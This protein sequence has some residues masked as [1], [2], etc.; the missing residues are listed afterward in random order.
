MPSS[1]ERKEGKWWWCGYSVSKSKRSVECA[2]SA[3]ATTNTVGK[4]TTI[5]EAQKEKN[6][7][8]GKAKVNAF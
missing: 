8:K 2:N 6:D 3:K 1:Y 5:S 7:K 4:A